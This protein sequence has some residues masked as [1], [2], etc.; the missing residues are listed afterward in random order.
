MTKGSLWEAKKELAD[1]SAPDS[2]TLYSGFP[3]PFN[4][5]TQIVFDLPESREVDV[6]IYNLLGQSVKSLFQGTKDAGTHT[7]CWEGTDS[8]GRAVSSGVYLV[9]LTAGQHKFQRKL[10]LIK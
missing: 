9:I 4:S 5:Q 10:V 2:F 7:L 6:T 1:L 8:Q 3:N